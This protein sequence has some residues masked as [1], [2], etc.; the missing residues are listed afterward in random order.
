ML[1][2]D[3]APVVPAASS[4]A[5]EHLTRLNMPSLR[6]QPDPRGDAYVKQLVSKMSGRFESLV[7]TR[8]VSATQQSDSSVRKRLSTRKDCDLNALCCCVPLCGRSFDSLQVLAWHMS[9]AHQDVS[10]SHSRNTICYL[11][12]YQ[13]FTAKG[14]NAHLTTKHRLIAERH[15]AECIEQRG[16]IIAPGAPAAERLRLKEV[17]RKTDAYA[18]RRLTPQKDAGTSGYD[19]FA[20]G[21]TTMGLDSDCNPLNAKPF[22]LYANDHYYQSS[23]GEN[24]GAYFVDLPVV[25]D[26]DEYD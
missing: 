10:V 7:S 2:T 16:S 4:S 13:M 3:S 19:R 5:D 9:Y 17:H 18:E 23:I 8:K 12:G 21:G 20:E 11:C 22:D 26:E 1:Q 15:N 6:Q 25:V 14:K 24:Y